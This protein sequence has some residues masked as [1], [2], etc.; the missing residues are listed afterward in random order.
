M[1]LGLRW[2]LRQV[3]AIVALISIV[4]GFFLGRAIAPWPRAPAVLIIRGDA[5]GDFVLA[6]GQLEYFRR[7]RPEY[8]ISLMVTPA[9]A[10]LAEAC[11]FV[12]EVIV[13]NPELHRRHLAYRLSF[14]MATARKGFSEVINPVFSRTPIADEVVAWT[15]APIRTG[16]LGDSSNSPKWL[17]LVSD[18]L[19]TRLIMVSGTTEMERNREFVQAFTGARTIPELRPRV[20]VTPADEQEAEKVLT[21]LG[22]SGRRPWVFMSVG[23]RASVR[24]WP[25]QRFAA[26]AVRLQQIYQI[27]TLLVAGPGEEEIVDRVYKSALF[28]P[29]LLPYPLSIRQVAA[30]LRRATCFVGGETGTMHLCAAVGIRGVGIVGGGHFGRFFPYS[31]SEGDIRA[32]FHTMPCYHCNWECIRAEPECITRIEVDDVWSAIVRLLNDLEMEVTR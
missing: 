18:R 12:D 13:W 2:V 6:A 23:A 10:D 3:D 14:L 1:R 19:Y 20:W 21:Q 16:H 15:G 7:S 5:I 31:N 29:K 17:K 26:I 28:L 4:L 25:P 27:P 22:L 32:V 30:I 8:R 11:P 24:I 9:V